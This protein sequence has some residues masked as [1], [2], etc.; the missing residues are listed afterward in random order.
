M[1]FSK[2]IAH[3]IDYI[4]FVIGVI[5]FIGMFGALGAIDMSVERHV[6]AAAGSWVALVI[7]FIMVV[8]SA[9]YIAERTKN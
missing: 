9:I 5:G 8:I 7:S 6:A 2:K 1:N 3:W 4:M